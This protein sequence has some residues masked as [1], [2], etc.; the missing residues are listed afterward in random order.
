MLGQLDS[1]RLHLRDVTAEDA[2][3]FFALDQDP[4]VMHFLGGV[5]AD[6]SL[7]RKRAM[8][9]QRVA[10]YATRPGLGLGACF[11]KST[12]EFVGWH[13]LRPREY[14]QY[15]AGGALLEPVE[16]AELGYRL[17]RRFWGQGYATEMSRALVRH[18]F[19]QLGLPQ[20]VAFVSPEHA[21][22]I[23]VLAKAGLERAGRARYADEDVDLYRILAP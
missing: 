14:R 15:D 20:I 3:A 5:I 16:H 8:L 17:A 22:S 2:A 10:T 18:G 9:E 13:M 12:A 19:E 21:A 7:Q 4:E 1:E 11:L 6:D 23:R